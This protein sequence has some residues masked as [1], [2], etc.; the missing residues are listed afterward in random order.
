MRAASRAH[1]AFRALSEPDADTRG[2]DK[3]HR[4]QRL[5]IAAALVTSCSSF[6]SV[7]APPEQDAS[8]PD[9]A[10]VPDAAPD[11]SGERKEPRELASDQLDVFALATNGDKLYFTVRGDGAVRVV[12]V[13]GGSVGDYWTSAP[14]T[15]P[16][17]LAVRGDAVFWSDTTTAKV[18]MRSPAAAY[19]RLLS[20]A[21]RSLTS[22]SNALYWSTTTTL[23]AAGLDL[24]D[25]Q[26]LDAGGN[27][28]DL[29]AYE[30][31]VFY[32]KASAGQVLEAGVP[33]LVIAQNEQ[34]CRSIAAS[35]LGVFWARPGENKVRARFEGDPTVFDLAIESAGP[36]SLAA[37]DGAVY[38]LTSSG[39]LRRW[40]APTG[41]VTTLV[42]GIG[43]PSTDYGN[44]QLLAVS[45]QAIFFADRS[46]RKIYRLS[47]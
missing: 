30:D 15:N 4:V 29:A 39:D 5:V 28:F 47:K 24:S 23:S 27:I 6:G 19:E 46:K 16:S 36:G 1:R 12:P 10:G 26:E 45:D 43:D 32:T 17:A 13:D 9:A 42:S 22:T 20:E 34:S 33:P 25:P 40:S 8:A 21:A 11:A 7:D 18:H 44:E 3:L 38:W 31:R 35:R 37:D 41:E 2:R 14:A